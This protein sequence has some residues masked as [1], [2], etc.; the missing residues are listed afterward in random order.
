MCPAPCWY[1]GLDRSELNEYSMEP[2]YRNEPS[3]HIY[4]TADIIQKFFF[5]TAIPPFP[6]PLVSQWPSILQI[7]LS[8]SR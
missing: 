5:F 6:T 3:R 7:R 2:Q 4:T 8:V 1:A